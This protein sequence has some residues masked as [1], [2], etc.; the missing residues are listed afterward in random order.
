V[1]R[2]APDQPEP[3]VIQ[4]SVRAAKTDGQENL[5]LAP[6][7]VVSVEQTPATVMVDVLKSFVRLGFNAAAP[8]F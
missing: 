3:L 8:G 6:G 2:H 4:V 5:P 7:D 1:I